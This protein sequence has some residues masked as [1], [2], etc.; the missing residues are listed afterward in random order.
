MAIV[1]VGMLDER[2]E[3]LR[4][5]RDRIRQRGHVTCLIDISVGTG[6]IVPTLSPM[7][8]A[9]NWLSWPKSARGSRSAGGTRRPRS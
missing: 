7:W 2:E 6:G 9:G 8:A 3:A 4:L 5:I 1:I